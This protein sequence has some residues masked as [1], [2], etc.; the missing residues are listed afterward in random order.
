M[1]GFEI[2]AKPDKNKR[3]HLL[4]Q[5]I[6]IVSCR[7]CRAEYDNEILL[8]Y[9]TSAVDKSA[10]FMAE[11]R[12]LSRGFAACTSKQT[13]RS[14][15]GALARLPVFSLAFSPSSCHRQREKTLPPAPK[16]T[17]AF[18]RVSGSKRKKTHG[19]RAFLWRRRGDSNSCAG[20]PTYALSRGASSPT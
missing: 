9:H 5:L 8:P 14:S 3:D 2:I 6:S 10:F 13:R 4:K 15:L 16:E 7:F 11:K 12:R 19:K 18:V 1:C 17:G 20:F